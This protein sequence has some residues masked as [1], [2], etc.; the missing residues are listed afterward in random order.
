MS[1]DYSPP[2]GDFQPADPP[3]EDIDSK[4]DRWFDEQEK[5]G[6]AVLSREDWKS[7]LDDAREEGRQDAQADSHRLISWA[8]GKLQHIAFTKQEDALALDEMKLMLMGAA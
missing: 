1:N 8:Y 4:W 6:M 2:L 3:E 5:G 7:K